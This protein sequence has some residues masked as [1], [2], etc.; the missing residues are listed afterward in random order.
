MTS[1]FVYDS[2]QQLSQTFNLFFSSGLFSTSFSTQ[3]FFSTSFIFIRLTSFYSNRQHK[4]FHDVGYAGYATKLLRQY[5]R[6]LIKLNFLHV[7][8][9]GSNMLHVQLSLTFVKKLFLGCCVASASRELQVQLR[10]KRLAYFF[11]H[12]F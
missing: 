11:V 9:I 2:L 10:L 6:I 4:L 1:F 8:D 7:G 12:H 3:V 5:C